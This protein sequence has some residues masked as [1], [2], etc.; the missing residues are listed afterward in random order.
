MRHA[1]HAEWTKLRT[2]PSNAWLALAIAG[3][4]V[5]A[6]VAVVWTVDTSH[7]PS[8]AE[9]FEDTTRLSLTGVR[10]GQVAV[11]VLAVGIIGGEYATGLIR[12]TLAACPQRRTVLATKAAVLTATVAVAGAFGVAGALLAGRIILPGNGFS[13]ANGYPPLSVTDPATLRAAAGTV[14]YLVLVGLLALGV[15][16][17]VRGTAA[18]VAG[19]LSLLYL[20]PVLT[21][22]VADPDWHDRLAKL[23]PMTAGLAVQ[24]TR[25]LDRLPVGP[26]AG[27]GVLAAWAA[28][29]LV[30]G[31]VLFA[32]RDQ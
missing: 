23:A 1:L 28:A 7:C 2:L 4:T 8:P 12:A 21:E 9:C 13:A 6:S 16:V 11:V 14:L 26:W 10:L 19:V 31:G 17:A 30:T 3:A 15:A 29:A 24:A 25:D 22:L 27:L 5:A 18:A 32:A 20:A